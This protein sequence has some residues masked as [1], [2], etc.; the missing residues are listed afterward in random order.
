MKRIERDLSLFSQEIGAL[1]KKGTSRKETAKLKTLHNMAKK[2]FPLFEEIFRT[3]PQMEELLISIE[4]YLD[5]ESMN[6]KTAIEKTQIYTNSFQE[7]VSRLQTLSLP[8]KEAQSPSP[9]HLN[10]ENPSY[11]YPKRKIKQKMASTPCPAVGNPVCSE[12]QT[13]I[14]GWGCCDNYAY[15]NG[16]CCATGLSCV[17][18]SCQ[19]LC[20]GSCSAGETCVN[21]TCCS[22]QQYC[23]GACCAEGQLCVSGVCTTPAAPCTCDTSTSTCCY[24]AELGYQCCSNSSTTCIPSTGNGVRAT[25][26]PQ[27]RYCNGSCCP[28]GWHCQNGQCVCTCT[29]TEGTSCCLDSC[30]VTPPYLC[31]Q[32]GDQ[33]G[34][35]AVTGRAECCSSERYCNGTCCKEGWHCQDGAC[36]CTCNCAQGTCCLDSCMVEP[37]YICCTGDQTCI[38]GNGTERAICC[39]AD[40]YNNGTCCPVGQHVTNNVCCPIGQKS[41]DGKTCCANTCCGT[42][43]CTAGYSCCHGECCSPSHNCCSDGCCSEGCC[44]GL[45]GEH[46]HCCDDKLCRGLCCKHKHCCN[47]SSCPEC[48]YW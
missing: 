10:K 5:L 18:G 28:E 26:C 38:N 45:C 40:R 31:C 34:K 2:M 36:V 35:N 23:A 48:G 4:D 43:C 12:S 6:L 44:G 15:C 8:G 39:P 33:C 41:C 47:K 7:K 22:E 16:E 9:L 20:H 11:W 25:C 13:C 17:N 46:A 29:C 37:P 27:S 42:K 30:Q 21:G 24:D 19:D 1:P 32:P 14:P 3:L